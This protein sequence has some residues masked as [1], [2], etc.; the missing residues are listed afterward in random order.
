MRVKLHIL[1]VLVSITWVSIATANEVPP[2]LPFEALDGTPLTSYQEGVASDLGVSATNQVPNTHPNTMNGQVV[3]E[4]PE[5]RDKNQQS[6][7]QAESYSYAL[8]GSQ[9]ADC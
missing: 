5:G 8:C 2:E 9:G 7:E 3:N 6:I 1:M 4:A